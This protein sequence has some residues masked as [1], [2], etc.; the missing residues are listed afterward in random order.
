MTVSHH[1]ISATKDT[2]LF[3][4][5]DHASKHIPAEYN[6]LGL[7]GDDLTRH[8]A[9]D[10]GTETIA[11]ELCAHFGCGGQVA[12]VSR[13]VIDLN[14]ELGADGLIPAT[15]D[16]TVIN[17]NENLSSAERQDRIDRFYAPYHAALGA[18]LEALEDPLVL[19]V[20][21]F[22]PQPK[23]GDFRPTDIGLLVKD[24]VES[25]EQ[26]RDGLTA[27]VPH[28]KIGM[29]KPYSAYDLN[30]TIDANVAPRGLRHLAIEL[31]QDHIDT[32]EKAQNMA[33]V[34]A[35]TLEP[36]LTRRRIKPITP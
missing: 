7:S 15:R 29:N 19:S 26:F 18:A 5:G 30:H 2:P 11:R 34:L 4:F 10:I 24:D 36:L 9:W 6:N 33:R 25:A 31:R 32:D 28:F 3:I 23:T 1:S 8:I 14:R 20:H 35:V 17:A 12:G 21:S 22:T 16:G 27:N 13:L